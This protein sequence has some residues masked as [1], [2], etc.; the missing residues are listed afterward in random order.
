LIPLCLSGAAGGMTAA[1]GTIAILAV[2]LHTGVMLATI[3]LIS[4]VVYEWVGLAFL[5]T[6]WINLDLVWILA[7]GFCGALLLIL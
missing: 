2:A 5:R 3:A 6:A 4:L 7:L 1:S